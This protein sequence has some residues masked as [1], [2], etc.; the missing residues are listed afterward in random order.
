MDIH[1]TGHSRSWT[2]SVGTLI[3]MTMV[4]TCL[5]NLVSSVAQ[6]IHL[7]TQRSCLGNSFIAVS[8][9]FSCF[10]RL[11]SSRHLGEIVL[12]QKSFTGSVQ[13]ASRRKLVHIRAGGVGGKSESEK[14]RHYNLLHTLT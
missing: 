13:F 14:K 12:Q 8:S 1:T 10:F 6:L 9:L 7:T 4:E 11:L 5:C 2:L 3:R